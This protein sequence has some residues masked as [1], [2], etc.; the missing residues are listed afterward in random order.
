LASRRVEGGGFIFILV[1]A[2]LGVGIIGWTL[3]I[4]A[5]GSL[6]CT[7]NNGL[8]PT[9]SLN[10]AKQ[11]GAAQLTVTLSST[12]GFNCTGV[13]TNALTAK[14]AKGIMIT[15]AYSASS[16]NVTGWYEWV[17]VNIGTIAPSTTFGSGVCASPFVQRWVMSLYM[18]VMGLANWFTDGFT[19]VLQSPVVG[20]SYYAWIDLQQ[21]GVNT[22]SVSYRNEGLSASSLS[23]IELQ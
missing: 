3:P 8:C 13:T 20:T 12:G 9:Y 23:L 16:V 14:T 17:I 2:A 18:P 19:F 4:D 5:G 21:R 7:Q 15:G 22:G 11:N 6:E 1:I 10:V